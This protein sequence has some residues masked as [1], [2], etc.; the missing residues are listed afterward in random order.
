M[1]FSRRKHRKTL[2][3]PP[4]SFC[5]G[6]L[7]FSIQFPVPVLQL[8]CIQIEI[9]HEPTFCF[10]KKISSKQ[11]PVFLKMFDVCES[12]RWRSSISF[13]GILFLFFFNFRWPFIAPSS[14]LWRSTPFLSSASQP[15]PLLLYWKKWQAHTKMT[16]S[17]WFVVV[18]PALST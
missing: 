4:L 1:F 3:P 12:L 14:F 13:L 5:F 2:P 15:G 9:L 8:V 18:S 6:T 11:R 10:T 16:W 17:L 7:F